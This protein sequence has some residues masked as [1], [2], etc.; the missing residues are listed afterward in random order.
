VNPFVTCSLCPPVVVPDRHS[1][2]RQM[3]RIPPA[4]VAPLGA[5]RVTS[6]CCALPWTLTDASHT[7]TEATG[8]LDPL[9]E[10]GDSHAH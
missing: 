9:L 5:Q 10:K 4:R 7:G 8:A 3:P 2:R 1:K 6:R